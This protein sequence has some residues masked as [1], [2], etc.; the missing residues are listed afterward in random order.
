MGT[1]AET[2]ALHD[3]RAKA[4]RQLWWEGGGRNEG[5]RR[6][7]LFLIIYTRGVEMTSSVLGCLC[8]GVKVMYGEGGEEGRRERGEELMSLKSICSMLWS[9]TKFRDVLFS[10]LPA[11][12]IS[13]DVFAFL[14]C[15]L[16]LTSGC[17]CMNQVS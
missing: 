6:S 7:M 14:F 1:C 9:H 4:L 15:V 16:P 2:Y 8:A 12:G 5:R 11:K 13:V 3:P 17:P 10:S